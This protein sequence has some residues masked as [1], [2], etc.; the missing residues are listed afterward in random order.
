MA[1]CFLSS[2]HSVFSS[3]QPPNLFAHQTCTS[4][5][6]VLKISLNGVESLMNELDHNSGTGG[7]GA[8]PRFF[9]ILRNDL[10][11]PLCNF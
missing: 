3:S 2:F 4:D 6:G 5:I 8:H 11:V 10:S 9:K 7:D 1:E